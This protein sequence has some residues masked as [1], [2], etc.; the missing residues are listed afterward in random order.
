M[1]SI[2]TQSGSSWSPDLNVF[3]PQDLLPQALILQCSTVAGSIEGDAPAVRVAYFEPDDATFIPEGDVIPEGTPSLSEALIYT[4]KISKL[5]RIS[6]EQFLQKS[7]AGQLSAGI[8]NALISAA[9]RAFVAQP[10]PVSAVTPPVGL[11]GQ[12][13]GVAAE[14][15]ADLDVLV[16]LL[17]GLQ[18]ADA[19]PSHILIDPVGWGAL[20]K[21]K[22]ATDSNQSLIG[23]GVQDAQTL[24]MGLPIIITTALPANTGIVIDSSDILS[25]VGPIEVAV[26]EDHFFDSD[27]IAMRATWRIGAKAIHPERLGLF[28]IA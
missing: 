20:K 23:A 9:D 5:L 19:Q 21:F 17:A 1:P 7:T 24:L 22:V 6:R 16:D 2:L 4:G 8:Q 18:A 11:I 14:V 13:I 15:D 3:K 10:A 25:A 12:A 28:E 27:S 26:S